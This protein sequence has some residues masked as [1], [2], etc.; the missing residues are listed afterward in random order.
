M[1]VTPS[2][3]TKAPVKPV[4]L[5]KALLPKYVTASGI[6][7]VPVKPLQ[8]LKQ[9]LSRYVTVEG[10]V[11]VPVNPVPWKDEF[12]IFIKPSGFV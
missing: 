9:P 12:P 3:I 7:N 8:L 5:L 4:Q 6:T 1:Y 2:D 10:M 11:S